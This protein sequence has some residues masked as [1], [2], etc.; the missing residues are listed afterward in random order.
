MGLVDGLREVQQAGT[1]AHGLRQGVRD[2]GGPAVQGSLDQAA[3]GPGRKALCQRVY[4]NQATGVYQVFPVVLNFLVLWGLH[5]PCVPEDAHP[6]AEHETRPR[7][8]SPGEIG[9]VEP[10]DAYI[11]GLVSHH[12]F[13]GLSMASQERLPGLPHVDHH[14]LLCVHLQAGDLAEASEVV[15]PAREEVQQVSYGAHSQALQPAGQGRGDPRQNCYGRGEGVALV[16]LPPTRCGSRPPGSRGAGGLWAGFRPGVQQLQGIL[17]PSPPLGAGYGGVAL[18]GEPYGWVVR[19]PLQSSGQK[20]IQ[21][22]DHRGI[23]V[24]L[25]SLQ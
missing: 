25:L 18:R 24:A 1:P 21:A 2:A 14:R 11:S 4:G 15:V 8:E 23:R 13:G 12:R 16:R 20:A 22:A 19:Q 6:S 3:N 9:L 7:P 10:D 17:Y 5:H